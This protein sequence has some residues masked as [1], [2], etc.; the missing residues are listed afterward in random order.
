MPEKRCPREPVHNIDHNRNKWHSG[1]NKYCFKLKCNGLN[2]N[3]TSN[4]RIIQYGLADASSTLCSCAQTQ[5]NTIMV[6]SINSQFACILFH[7]YSCL[8]INSKNTD[9]VWIFNWMVDWQL[10]YT[11]T[12]RIY[13]YDNCCCNCL[14]LFKTKIRMFFSRCVH[15]NRIWRRQMSSYISFSVNAI[16]GSCSIISVAMVYVL[17]R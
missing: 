10:I 11:N 7:P 14:Q 3:A 16:A 17:C 1:I 2:E 8:S 6:F 15:S 4:N 9:L 13:L 12:V 5:S